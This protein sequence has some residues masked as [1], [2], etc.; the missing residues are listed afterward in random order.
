MSAPENAESELQ[1][2]RAARNWSSKELTGRIAWRFAS[3]FFRY[4]PRLA[5][6]WRRWILRCFGARIGQ[7]VH[8]YPTCRIVIPW[9]LEIGDWSTVGDGAILYA[10]GRIRIGRNVTI[11]QGAHLCAGTHDFESPRFDLQKLP[12]TVGD[13]AWICAEAFVGP[14]TTVEEGAVVAAR[15]VVV[16]SVAAYQIVGG[17]PAKVIAERKLRFKGT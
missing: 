6:G 10:L 13:F 2:R 11:S 8:L 16:K 9:T 1:K 5:W 12:I 15:A 3:L 14:N 4:S 7:K 17:N